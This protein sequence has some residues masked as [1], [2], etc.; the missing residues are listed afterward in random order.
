MIA[1]QGCGC[2]L[3]AN[4]DHEDF[5]QDLEDND[6]SSLLLNTKN[7]REEDQELKSPELRAQ[8]N[9][10]RDSEFD[11]FAPSLQRTPIE[12]KK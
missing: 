6:H 2:F 10:G 1:N 11:V 7:S 9:C 4:V 5:I 8:E 12:A 3:D